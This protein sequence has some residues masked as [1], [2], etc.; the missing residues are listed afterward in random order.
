MNKPNLNEKEKANHGITFN[1]VAIGFCDYFIYKI[2]CG[3][4]NSNLGIYEDF[5]KKIISVEN[6]MQN[7]LKINNLLKHEKNGS[8]ESQ[9]NFGKIFIEVFL[10]G[11][12]KIFN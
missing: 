1:S 6:L 9:K 2:T 8:N 12:K 4:K 11:F 7:Y 10:F 3:K 5:R